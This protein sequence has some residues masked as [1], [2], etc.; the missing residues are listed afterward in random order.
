[1]SIPVQRLSAGRRERVRHGADRLAALAQMVSAHRA[2][3]RPRPAQDSRP[4]NPSGRRFGRHDWPAGSS[5][6]GL[7]GA[8]VAE[9]RRQRGE[10]LRSCRVR[11][12]TSVR[13]GLLDPNSAFLL[14]YGLGRR[15]IEL[16]GIF[17]GA[18][19]ILLVGVAGRQARVASP[20]RNSP[21]NSSSPPWSPPAARASRSLSPASSSATPSPSCGFSPSL[22]PSTS[23]TT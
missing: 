9:G 4:A 12:M 5:S 10:S 15:A 7:P 23:W 13:L 16:A 18:F 11:P 14:Q 20:R 1:M 19:G 6:A 22:T 21:A 2:G 8:L 17:L 3:G